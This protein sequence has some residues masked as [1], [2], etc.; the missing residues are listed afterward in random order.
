MLIKYPRPSSF[1]GR[2]AHR[3]RQGTFSVI[4]LLAKLAAL[5]A[6]G[7]RWRMFRRRGAMQDADRKVA[8]AAVIA[9]GV[10][11]AALLWLCFVGPTDHG[12]YYSTKCERNCDVPWW[13]ASSFWMVFFTA[14]L[15][16]STYLLWRETRR[17]ARGAIIQEAQMA[18]SIDHAKKSSE[19]ELQAYFHVGQ[20]GNFSKGSVWPWVTLK[21]ENVGKTPAYDAVFN[22]HVHVGPNPQGSARLPGFA[23]DDTN[24]MGV[25][26]PSVDLSLT[27]R[28]K[29]AMTSEQLTNLCK[30]GGGLALYVYG[31]VTFRDAFDR[32]RYHRFKLYSDDINAVNGLLTYSADGNE[33]N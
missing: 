19:R 17:L 5:E 31:E 10:A 24:V 26:S 12:P 21:I 16:A 25:I 32:K 7:V 29:S 33:A 22:S 20:E 23:P 11:G 1:F 8:W 3:S 6:E 30:E 13:A 9:L 4:F 27:I 14:I 18:E 28:A 2:I 15:T